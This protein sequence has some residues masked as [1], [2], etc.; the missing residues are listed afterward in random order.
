MNYRILTDGDRFMLEYSYDGIKYLPHT[1][2]NWFDGMCIGHTEIVYFNTI[3]KAEKAALKLL[4]ILK[5]TKWAV[6][7]EDTIT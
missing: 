2:N 6:V 4:N 5:P 7:K 1:K 3:E